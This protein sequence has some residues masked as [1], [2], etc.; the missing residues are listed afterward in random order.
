MKSTQKDA[1]DILQEEYEKTGI[2][3]LKLRAEKSM[4]EEKLAA[5]EKSLKEMRTLLEAKE[6]VIITLQSGRSPLT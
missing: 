3:C 5:C 4:L 6:R 2:E 1:R